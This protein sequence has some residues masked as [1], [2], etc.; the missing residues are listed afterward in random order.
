MKVVAFNGSARKNGNT[1]ILVKHVFQELQK[2]GS[3]L[4]P[5]YWLHSPPWQRVEN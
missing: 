1:G 5:G 4:L 3:H 2:Q